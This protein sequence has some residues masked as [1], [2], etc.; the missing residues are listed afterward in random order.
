MN[1]S[2]STKGSFFSVLFNMY[3]FQTSGKLI[4]VFTS[5]LLKH[6]FTIIRNLL[7]LTKEKQ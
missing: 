5:T 7:K 2:A 6:N 1:R 3:D 4:K